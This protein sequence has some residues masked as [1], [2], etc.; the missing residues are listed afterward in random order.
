MLGQVV[1]QSFPGGPA[2]T[3]PTPPAAAAR[4][5]AS[6][7]L[8]GP[9]A[10][11][12]VAIPKPPSPSPATAPRPAAGA[13]PTEPQGRAASAGL[14]PAA[15]PPWA[16][17]R[18]S[19]APSAP[20][21]SARTGLPQAPPAA[22]TIVASGAVADQGIAPAAAAPTERREGPPRSTAPA[23]LA[24]WM[25]TAPVA[26]PLSPAEPVSSSPA[27]PA[28]AHEPH[29]AVSPAGQT[30]PP[31]PEAQAAA[32]FPSGLVPTPS[33]QRVAQSAPIAFVMASSP[34]VQQEALAPG[35]P[36]ERSLAPIRR[37][38]AVPLSSSGGFAAGP[39]HGD[40]FLDGTRVG[41]WMSEAL[42]RAVGGPARGSTA[43]DPRMGPRW[44]G[45]L[46]GH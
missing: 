45:A 6:S 44:P 5:P 19:A 42:A 15:S 17:D 23:T 22:A 33:P 21:L 8:P 18:M 25:Q 36:A 16:Q 26:D 14:P 31:R 39:T 43:F 3:P 4:L 38:T 28:L 12:S 10:R 40:V 35:A 13:T 11:P 27:G 29:E 7:A 2:V 24:S 20:A 1:R 32:A 37:E 30:L 46:Q 41:H 34:A 9:E